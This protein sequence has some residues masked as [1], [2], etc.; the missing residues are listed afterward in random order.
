M[1]VYVSVV[2]YINMI[3]V[4]PVLVVLIRMFLLCFVPVKASSM[5]LFIDCEEDDGT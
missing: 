3:Y 4:I 2:P 1:Y 5:S